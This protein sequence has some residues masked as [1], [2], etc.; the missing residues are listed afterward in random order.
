MNQNE[1][2]PE[3]LGSMTVQSLERLAHATG[4][5]FAVPL[6]RAVAQLDGRQDR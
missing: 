1:T 3:D 4:Q 2:V 5:D 6:E